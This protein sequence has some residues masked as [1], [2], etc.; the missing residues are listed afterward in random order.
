MTQVIR[1]NKRQYLEG[2]IAQINRDD[3]P[4]MLPHRNRTYLSLFLGQ[5][6]KTSLYKI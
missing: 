5:K 3:F 1:T 2:S 4:L 6:I